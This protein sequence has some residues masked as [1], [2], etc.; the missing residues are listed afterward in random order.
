MPMVYSDN[1][2]LQRDIPLNIS[3]IADSGEK[4]TLEINGQK[5]TTKAGENGKWSITLSPLKAGGPYTL[6]IRAKSKPL[7]YKNV[8]VGEV[9][10]C[11]GQSNMAQKMYTQLFPQPDVWD[12]S[13]TTN[14]AMFL[15]M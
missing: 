11:S 14:W 9:W 3:G 1:M 10:L 15:T 5:Q 12:M 7:L 2:V 4:V 13:I 6:T 8:L